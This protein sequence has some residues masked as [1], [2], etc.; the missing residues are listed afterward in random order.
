YSNA[1]FL[2]NNTV[3]AYRG[4]GHIFRNITNVS[5]TLRTRKRNAAILHAEKGSSFI[6]LSVQDGVLFLELQ[7][8]SGGL[9]GLEDED[10]EV[11][12]EEVMSSVSLSS[13]KSIIDGEW[14]TVHLFMVAPWAQ[15]SRWSLVLD[16]EIEEASISRS[17]GSNL[18]F[19]REGVDIYLGGLAPN[20]GWSLVGCLGTVE[21]GGIALP[22]FRSSEVNLP[23]L[24]KEQFVQTSS[25]PALPGCSGAPMCEPSP[26]LNNGQC[27][28]LFNT[29]NCTCAEG[30][31]GRRCNVLIDTCASRPCVHGNCTVNG[32]T[33]E[34]TCEFGYTG[35]DCEEEV[36]V[37]ENHMCAN[38]A[39]CL[40]GPEKYACLCAENYT[41]SLC[42]E[43]VEETP[44][45][46]I[47]RKIRPKLPVSVCGDETR[48]YTCFN[49]GNCTD[50][51]LSCNCPPGFIGHSTDQKFGYT[52]SLK[53]LSS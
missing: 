3:I 25:E 44:W 2:N 16:D 7:S 20:T 5:L 4:N 53:E 15:S 6:T 51:E 34:C 22:Y 50:R 42:S 29:Y 41:G 52:F 1:T 18:N 39:T 14:H 11:I 43:R 47:A 24:Q 28:D 27:Q 37:C 33:Y 8:S 10:K 30:W 9:S 31:A 12:K 35:V 40:H 49:G 17:Q 46:I 21:L 48:N 36:D 38:G 23:R 45:Y 32:F 26:C 19:L 13:K